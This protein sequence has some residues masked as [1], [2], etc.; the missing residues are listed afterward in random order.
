V[1]VRHDRELRRGSPSSPTLREPYENRVFSGAPTSSA[2]HRAVDSICT[3]F[4]GEPPRGNSEFVEPVIVAALMYPALADMLALRL[5]DTKRTQ[6]LAQ[7][8]G[9]HD[10]ERIGE[11]LSRSFSVGWTIYGVCPMNHE[12]T[13]RASVT[14]SL[15]RS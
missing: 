5:E 2:T 7:G 13:L 4:V 12:S 10:R 11:Y 15:A 3:C 9:E 1:I 8:S 6:H 14:I